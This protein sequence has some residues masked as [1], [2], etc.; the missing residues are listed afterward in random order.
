MLIIH[1]KHCNALSKVPD[2]PGRHAPDGT[3]LDRFPAL[4]D[5]VERHKHGLS[6][7]EHPGASIPYFID[8]SKYMSGD[9]PRTEDEIENDAVA[10]V[11][12]HLADAGVQAGELRDELK[13]DAMSCW[14]K[15]QRPEYPGR[16]CPDY[17]SSAKLIGRKN[18]AKEDRMY[19]CAFCPY[20]VG[21]ETEKRWRRGGYR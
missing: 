11:K 4:E 6:E 21:V 9:V 10:Y 8:E 3:M 16:R 1:C 19:L 13:D 18:M 15:H 12:S 17:E 5:Y 20:S 14:E 7:E 2:Y